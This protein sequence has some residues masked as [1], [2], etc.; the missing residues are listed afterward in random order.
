MLL[1][2]NKDFR[3]LYLGQLFSVFGDWIKTVSLIGFIYHLTQNANATGLL[4]ILAIVPQIFISF[5]SGPF[6]DRFNKRNLIIFL[7]FIRFLLGLLLVCVMYTENLFLILTIILITNIFSAIFIPTRSAFIPQITRKDEIVSANN[8]LLI[9]F[10]VTMAVSTA[11]GG[12]ILSY[13]GSYNVLIIASIMYL[14]SA[15]LV[16]LIKASKGDDSQDTPKRFNS[17]YLKELKEGYKFV[18]DST[19][20]KSTFLLNGIRDFVLGAVNIMFNT[21][22]LVSF[23]MG[24]TGIAYGYTATALGY[25]ALGFFSKKLIKQDMLENNRKLGNFCLIFITLYGILLGIAFSMDSFWLFLLFIL[26]MNIPQGLLNI[27][28]ESSI[29]H[30]TKDSHRGRVFA[31][32]GTFTKLGYVFGLSLF[33]ILSNFISIVTYSWVMCLM[34]IVAGFIN[35]KISSI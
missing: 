2:Q 25:I 19:L 14:I 16:L 26:I 35:K 22:I 33:M 20:L 27:S 1:T 13:I 21:V 28:F 32:L 24:D 34:L 29:M 7:D 8:I 31:F 17:S 10:N 9:S 6:I 18:R 4:F 15:L 3:Y 12:I 30:N 23:S 11:I 5:I